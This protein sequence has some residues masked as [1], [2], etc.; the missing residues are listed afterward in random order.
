MKEIIHKRFVCE[1]CGKEYKSP[2]YCK[3]H[4]EK[5]KKIQY[6]LQKLTTYL[7]TLVNHFHKLGYIVNFKYYD[8]ETMELAVDLKYL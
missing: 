7:Q 5:C 4:E 1:C 6:D 3:S 2:K 8:F